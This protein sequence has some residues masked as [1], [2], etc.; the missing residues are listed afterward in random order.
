MEEEEHEIYRNDG[1]SALD[2]W[3][4]TQIEALVREVLRDRSTAISKE[5]A[6]ISETD[7]INNRFLMWIEGLEKPTDYLG[8]VPRLLGPEFRLTCERTAFLDRSSS[9]GAT[10]GVRPCIEF[11]AGRARR[12]LAWR[13]VV[14][15]AL[16]LLMI[17]C[18]FAFGL[19]L[20]KLLRLWEGYES[21]WTHFSHYLE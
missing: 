14:R 20:T 18:I 13:W 19:A 10:V 6:A 3:D 7:V 16:I 21:P 15:W 2:A 1:G 9:A 4:L 12:T 11:D 8:E 17:C 5:H